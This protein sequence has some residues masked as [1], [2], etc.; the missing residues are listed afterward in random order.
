MPN[1]MSTSHEPRR[2]IFF[3]E[4]RVLIESR[5]PALN[6]IVARATSVVTST[7]RQNTNNDKSEYKRCLKWLLTSADRSVSQ[8]QRRGQYLGDI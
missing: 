7:L 5:I 6:F 1:A 2:A 4:A 3:D 8:R